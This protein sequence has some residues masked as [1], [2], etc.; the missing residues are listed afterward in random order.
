MAP[1]SYGQTAV[2]PEWSGDRARD[3]YEMELVSLCLALDKPVLGIC[4]GAQVLNV[5]LGG[6]LWQDI[7]TQHPGQRVHRDWDVYDRHAHDVTIEPD[8]RLAA[9]M[10]TTTATASCHHHQAI[11]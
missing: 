11:D 6:T 3:E 4:R 9:V 10:D 5:T 7:A 8:S 2:R 1:E